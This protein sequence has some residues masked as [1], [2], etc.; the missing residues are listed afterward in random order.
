MSQVNLPTTAVLSWLVLNR[1]YSTQQ[2]Y[3]TALLLFATVA[4]LQV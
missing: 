2:W 4:F 1:Q 3:S